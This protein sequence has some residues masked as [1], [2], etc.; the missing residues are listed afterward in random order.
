[1]LDAIP[2]NSLGFLAMLY[3][4]TAMHFLHAKICFGLS[5]TDLTS[6]SL[7]SCNP[8]E[9]HSAFVQP[10]SQRF[11]L[12]FVARLPST[13]LGD[14]AC[15]APGSIAYSFQVLV[16]CR[17]VVRRCESRRAVCATHPTVLLLVILCPNASSIGICLLFV[18]HV[19]GF[20]KR[21]R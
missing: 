4:Q 1:M 3:V 12:L 7:I 5:R 10:S 6:T 17:V 18:Y 11:S 21:G 14:N 13:R 16:L 2:T 8:T 15:C 20:S 19:D 9:N